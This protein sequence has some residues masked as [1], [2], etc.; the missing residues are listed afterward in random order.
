[1]DSPFFLESETS[2]TGTVPGKTRQLAG[3]SLF[4]P[5]N[6]FS[7]RMLHTKDQRAC[8]FTAVM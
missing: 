6:E 5:Q 7:F 3:M 4:H 2:K 1:M 8:F